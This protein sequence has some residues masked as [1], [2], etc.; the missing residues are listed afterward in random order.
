MVSHS[1]SHYTHCPFRCSKKRKD[2]GLGRSRV[3]E[4]NFLPADKRV[5]SS[6]MCFLFYT[7]HSGRMW[8]ALRD[9]VLIVKLR[10]KAPAFYQYK[11]TWPPACIQHRAFMRDQTSIKS[12]W[13]WSRYFCGRCVSI[14]RLLHKVNV[15]WNNCFRQIFNACYL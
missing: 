13:F 3:N 15:A 12:F 8:W 9:N 10:I 4:I 6:Q 5:C 2:T 1:I 11:L 14:R 7:A